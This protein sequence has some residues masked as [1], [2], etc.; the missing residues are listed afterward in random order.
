MLQITTKCL[1][2]QNTSLL[3]FYRTTK[4]EW[5]ANERDQNTY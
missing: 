1:R 4:P 2:T 5:H 3:L